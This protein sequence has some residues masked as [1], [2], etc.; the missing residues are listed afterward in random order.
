MHDRIVRERSERRIRKS[1]ERDRLAAVYLDT[2]A[3]E[4]RSPDLR[5]RAL[6]IVERFDPE[7]YELPRDAASFFRLE[8][9][10]VEAGD[11]KRVI[12]RLREGGSQ[13]ARFEGRGRSTEEKRDFRRRDRERLQ[14]GFADGTEGR[15]ATVSG[16]QTTL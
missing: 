4:E 14:L 15:I 3:L 2:G 13:L 7:A 12:R 1:W 11:R 5:R 6:R 10:I 16:K 9:D 8:R